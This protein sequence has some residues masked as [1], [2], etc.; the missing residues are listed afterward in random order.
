MHAVARIAYRGCIDNIQASWVKM[1]VEG[2]RQ[3]LQAGVNDLGGTLMD[4][5]I[6]RAAGA[7]HGQAHGRGGIR[8][9]RGAP[10]PPP[11]AAH[12]AVRQGRHCC[13]PDAV[14]RKVDDGRSPP[15]RRR[16]RPTDADRP[17]AG[18]RR[19]RRSQ[20]LRCR[21]VR[22]AAPHPRGDLR[23]RVRHRGEARRGAAGLA[24]VHARVTG[25][26]YAA[27]DPALLLWVHA[28]LVD[29]AMRVHARFLRPLS[30]A[31]AER[32]YDESA[33]VA[34]VLGIPRTQRP[35]NLADFRDYVRTMVGSLEVTDTARALARRILHPRVPVV[36]G[37]GFFA[38]RQLTVGL[39]PPPLRAQYGF[40]WDSRRNAALDLLAATSRAAP[41][42]CAS[43]PAPHPAGP[44][45]V[46]PGDLMP[47]RRDGTPPLPQR[48]P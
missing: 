22:P 28:T 12:H 6:S 18:G 30:D 13:P 41:P 4:E 39:L 19:R 36:A 44:R 3:L 37:P 48:R 7:S 40:A 33:V 23:H 32:Y 46:S 34:E 31:E 25:P 10:R 2:V 38:V 8:R 20:R 47:A 42:S 24:K 43:R 5:N 17:P 45:G 15:A 11:R 16:S 29:T 35:R 26:G 21:S 27:N 1:G 9:D 14:I